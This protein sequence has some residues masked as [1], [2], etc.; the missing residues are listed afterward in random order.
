M[1]KRVGVLALQ[2]DFHRH[3]QSLEKLQIP[4][5]AVRWPDDLSDCDAL[6]LPGGES[7]TFMNLMNQTGLTEAI[8]EF[9]Q[10]KPLMGTCAGLIVLA[11]EVVNNHIDPLGLIDLRVERNAYGRQINS[12]SE[13]IQI[14]SFTDQPKFEAVF[15]RAP[16]IIA[17]GKGTEALGFYL[18]QVVMAR[19]ERVLAATFHP[20]L[21][22]DHRIHDFF[23]REFV[24]RN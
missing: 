6:I 21:T 5:K 1:K 12:F 17:L 18:D 19:N 8:C 15:I 23:Y 22:R 24:E 3:I 9:G 20:E 2:G 4:S 16:K 7:T 13:K 14:P 10:K 11:T